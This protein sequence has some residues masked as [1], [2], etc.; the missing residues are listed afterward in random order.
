[1]HM[2]DALL[3]AAAGGTMC[4]VSAGFIGHSISKIKKNDLCERC[5]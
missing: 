1:M 4:A 5:S 3:S 2:P